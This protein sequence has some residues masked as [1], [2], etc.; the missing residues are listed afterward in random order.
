MKT[1]MTLIAASSLLAAVAIAQ[2]PRYG[3]AD[4]GTLGGQNGNA[5]GPNGSNDL[6]V[7]AET[8]TP[9]PLGEDFCGFGTHLICL[10][11]F[12]NGVMTPLPT[13]GGNN[14]EAFTLN[15]R[16]QIVGMAENS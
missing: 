13:L 12:W 3:V 1:I 2:P 7:L 10:G 8:S 11:A 16:S 5:A 4:V 14:A 9:D 15:D 6:A